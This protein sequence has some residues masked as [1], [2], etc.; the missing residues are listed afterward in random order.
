MEYVFRQHK[1]RCRGLMFKYYWGLGSVTGQCESWPIWPWR[2]ETCWCF[3]VLNSLGVACVSGS[4][5]SL[6]N[7]CISFP[8]SFFP[9]VSV[10]ALF[11]DEGIKIK[12]GILHRH[13]IEYVQDIPG[14]FHNKATES[15]LSESHVL[16]RSQSKQENIAPPLIPHPGGNV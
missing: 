5:F 4:I 12:S 14:S 9:S 11:I 3:K 7:L 15:V 8:L 16:K 1:Q 10:T 13:A 6:Q 2:Q